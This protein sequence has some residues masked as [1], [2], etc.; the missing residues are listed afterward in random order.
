[1]SG[2]VNDTLKLSKD[3]IIIIIII[4]FFFILKGS[5]RQNNICNIICNDISHLKGLECDSYVKTLRNC[6]LPDTLFGRSVVIW[7]IGRLDLAN[8]FVYFSTANSCIKKK[9]QTHEIANFSVGKA[10]SI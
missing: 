6:D 5:E 4:T 10:R 8:I 3:I 2:K 7:V 9:Q 1:M